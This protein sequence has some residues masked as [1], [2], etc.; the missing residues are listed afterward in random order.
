MQLKY[1]LFDD[2]S[3]FLEPRITMAAF[4][5]KTGKKEEGRYIAEKYTDNLFNLNLGIEI[6]MSDEE[7]RKGRSLDRED[8]FHPSFFASAGA[9]M[10]C[11]LARVGHGRARVTR[12]GGRGGGAGDGGGGASAQT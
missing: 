4:T 7:T 2:L 11:A 12:S 5:L 9:G 8:Y 3:V 10:G 1:R 6:A